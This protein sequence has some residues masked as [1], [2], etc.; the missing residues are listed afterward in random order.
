MN[1]S[2]QREIV[3]ITKQTERGERGGRAGQGRGMTEGPPA[4]PHVAHKFAEACSTHLHDKVGQ[5]HN[6]R[7]S[8]STHSSL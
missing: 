1:A 6:P 4:V 5:K 7:T 2:T 8:V 3:G